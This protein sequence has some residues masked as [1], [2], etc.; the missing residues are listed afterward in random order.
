MNGLKAIFLTEFCGIIV[1]C[2]GLGQLGRDELDRH[3][4]IDQLQRIPVAGDDHAVPARMATAFSDR[5]DHIVGFP[6]LAFKNRDA[7]GPQHILH[8]GHLHGKLVRHG[9]AR[10][11]IAVIFQ[12]AECWRFKVKRDAERVRLFVRAQLFQNIQKAINGI[13]KEPVS[14]RQCT[15]AIIGAVD[16]AVSVENHQ[17][18]GR[19]LLCISLVSLPHF[20]PSFKKGASSG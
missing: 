12:M 15:D 6:A 7:H 17:L 1:D 16:D 11:L 9:M 5:A 8:N 20:R 10:G 14:G 2:D 18:H 3:V 4:F 19:K 13:C